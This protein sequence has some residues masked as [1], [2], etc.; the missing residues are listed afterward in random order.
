ML[1]YLWRLIITVYPDL[2]GL[3][4]GLGALNRDRDADLPSVRAV[5]ASITRGRPFDIWTHGSGEVLHTHLQITGSAI[6]AAA[7]DVPSADLR[8]RHAARMAAVTGRI[9]LVL[10][11]YRTALRVLVIAA[12]AAIGVGVDAGIEIGIEIG[13]E[14]A[15][16]PTPPR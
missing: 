3:W 15:G 6:T 9:G 12:L 2:I 10:A 8:G 14:I 5:A 16:A 11:L 13:V 1:G 4:R 7:P